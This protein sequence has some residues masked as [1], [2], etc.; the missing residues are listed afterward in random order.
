MPKRLATILAIAVVAGCAVPAGADVATRAPQAVTDVAAESAEPAEVS[1]VSMSS[2]SPSIVEDLALCEVTK[3]FDQVA[4]MGIVAHASLVPQYAPF[5]GREPELQT[6]SEAFVVT[7]SGMV[8]IPTMGDIGHPAYVDVQDSTC[9][10]IDGINYWFITGPSVDSLG[11]K[12]T[13]E[14]VAPH[15]KQLPAPLP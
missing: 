12:N 15:P 8:R 3:H 11:H 9:V 10:V 7:Y 5:T 13:P 14:A 2:T 4:G 6:M 1:P